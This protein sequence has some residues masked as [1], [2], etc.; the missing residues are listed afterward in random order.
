[1]ITKQGFVRRAVCGGLLGLVVMVALA[2]AEDIAVKIR[3]FNFAPQRVSVEAV[4]TVTGTNAGDIPHTIA[5]TTKA[6]RSKALDTEYDTGVICDTQK[7]AERLAM[8]LDGNE[9]TAIATVNAEERDPSACAVE[10]VAFV[11]GASLAR[12]E[13]SRHVCCGRDPGRRRRP[14]E[15]LPKHRAGRPFHAGQDRRAQRVGVGWSMTNGESRCQVSQRWRDTCSTIDPAQPTNSSFSYLMKA[16]TCFRDA[17][18]R[19]RRRSRTQSF[20]KA[21]RT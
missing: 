6:F 16:A 18:A 4:A 9:R 15:R 1:M 12:G 3:N 11:R 10:T 8:L 7:Q 2:E 20:A 13:Q 17:S 19:I 5:S 14:R 21:R